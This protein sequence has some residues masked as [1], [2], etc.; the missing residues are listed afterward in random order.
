M[1]AKANAILLMVKTKPSN[2]KA[3]CKSYTKRSTKRNGYAEA[4]AMVAADDGRQDWVRFKSEC[5]LLKG[6]KK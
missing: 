4:M 3:L 6:V 2:D 5:V 1:D